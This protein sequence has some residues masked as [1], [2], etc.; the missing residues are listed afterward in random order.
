MNLNSQPL[1]FDVPGTY[2]I[3]VRGKL[4]ARWS[5]SL[6]GMAISTK[7]ETGSHPI[8]T[9]HGALTDQAALMGVLTALYDMGYTL[10]VHPGVI[11]SGVRP[12]GPCPCKSI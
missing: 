9:L 3:R 2:R 5:A 1:L 10:L 6:G 7:E 11:T 8:T 12:P 4:A